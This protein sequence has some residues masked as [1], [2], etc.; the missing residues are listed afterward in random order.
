MGKTCDEMVSDLIGRE[1]TVINDIVGML[2]DREIDVLDNLVDLVSALCNIDKDELLSRSN[3]IT[4]SQARWLYWYT[5]RYATGESYATI[6]DKTEF[7]CG[8]KYTLQGVASSINKMA[9]MISKEPIWKKRWT[10]MYRLIKAINNTPSCE[11]DSTI[12]I[13]VPKNLSKVVKIE[14]KEK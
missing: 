6:A 9:M 7:L 12:V 5:Y 4:V 14:I 10:I 13:H 1:R 2:R 3:S 8:R 11:S